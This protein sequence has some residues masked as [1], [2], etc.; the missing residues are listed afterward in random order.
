M[1]K[2]ILASQS[3]RRLQLLSQI[4]ITPDAV[5][6]ADI[7]ETP[8]QNEHP[9]EYVK[10]VA[11][12][13]AQ[14]IAAKH[15][16][17]IVLAADTSVVLGRQILGK[18]GSEEEAL[19]FLRKLSG[20]RHKVIGGVAV[21]SP[22]GART[23][24]IETIVK[25]KKLTEEDIKTYIASGEWQDRAGAY[26]IQDYAACFVHGIIGSYSNIVGLSLLE[27]KE[28]LASA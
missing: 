16:D 3:P 22:K 10:R 20:R 19:S 18:A 6:P 9:K 5:M 13:K 28:M 7:D 25:F 11:L 2:L 27:V 15:P 26:S 12:E 14:K 21:I 23:K 4:N 8:H 24:A 1:T 17:D